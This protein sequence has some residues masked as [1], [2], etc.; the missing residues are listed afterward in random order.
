MSSSSAGEQQGGSDEEAALLQHVLATTTEL[1]AQDSQM[2]EDVLTKRRALEGLHRNVT[3]PSPPTSTGTA[4]VPKPKQAKRSVSSDTMRSPRQAPPMRRAQTDT[5]NR[6][7]K[8]RTVHQENETTIPEGFSSEFLMDIVAERASS[9]TTVDPFASH[10]DTAT[11]I[12][13]DEMMR[14]EKVAAFSGMEP[15]KRQISTTT[16]TNIL[17][18]PKAKRSVSS[19]TTR[20]RAGP[21]YDGPDRTFNRAHKARTVH[22]EKKQPF[23]KSSSSF[24]WN[25]GRT[26]SSST[27]GPIPSPANTAMAISAD[28]MRERKNGGFSA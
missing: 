26:A 11:A 16:G 22:Q 15:D 14:N 21:P 25:C 6:A 12:S 4:I 1:S 2:L 3:P 8:A 17:P 24:S 20:S 10:A 27:T 23:Q 9:S 28:E 7:H 13:A 19:D 5:L 18:K